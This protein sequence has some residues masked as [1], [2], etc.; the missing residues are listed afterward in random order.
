MTS[1]KYFIIIFPNTPIDKSQECSLKQGFPVRYAAAV[2]AAKNFSAR[3]QIILAEREKG[4]DH[5]SVNMSSRRDCILF[6]SLQ[7]TVPV[8]SC[9]QLHKLDKLRKNFLTSVMCWQQ[10]PTTSII[11]ILEGIPVLKHYD[12]H[13][14]YELELLR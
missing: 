10:F 12:G 14:E 1:T 3:L 6:V 2:A 13:V 11:S 7:S 8:S 4:D 5:F 9:K